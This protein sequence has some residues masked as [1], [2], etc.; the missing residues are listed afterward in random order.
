M[1]NV[2]VKLEFKEAYYAMSLLKID[3]RCLDT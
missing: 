1:Y 2:H 3:E